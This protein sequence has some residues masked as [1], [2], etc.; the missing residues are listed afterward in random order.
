[1]KQIQ[2]LYNS[3]KRE[4]KEAIKLIKDGDSVCAPL[5]VGEPPQY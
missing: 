4:V 3:K 2:E 5:G 1:M